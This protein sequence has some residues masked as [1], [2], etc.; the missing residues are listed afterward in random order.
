MHFWAINPRRLQLINSQRRGG[1]EAT[2]LAGCCNFQYISVLIP[3]VASWLN[4]LTYKD[5]RAL[6]VAVENLKT[7]LS[8]IFT[9]RR[10]PTGILS[11]DSENRKLFT[12]PFNFPVPWLVSIQ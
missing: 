6:N 10:I 5:V 4:Y 2:V 11:K 9:T 7:Q 3:K 12:Y 8:T 1:I